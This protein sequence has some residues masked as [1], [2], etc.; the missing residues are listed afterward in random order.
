MRTFAE[1]GLRSLPSRIMGRDHL[2]NMHFPHAVALWRPSRLETLAS[3]AEPNSGVLL[4]DSGYRL[5]TI[6]QAC[7]YNSTPET[8]EASV[9]GRTRVNNLFTLDVFLFPEGT[10]LGDQWV[11]YLLTPGDNAHRLY[12]CQGA[13]QSVQPGPLHPMGG[14]RALVARVQTTASNLPPGIELRVLNDL[15]G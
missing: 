7:F 15:G 5:A 13:P 2:E 10:E 12:I 11:L 9:L 14:Q 4:A 8:N 6:Y 3:S 1:R